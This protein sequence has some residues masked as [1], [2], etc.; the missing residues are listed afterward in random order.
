MRR[1]VLAS[2]LTILSPASLMAE[3]LIDKVVA[4]V[5]GVP[6]LHSEVETKVRSGFFSVSFFPAAEDAPIFEK[7]LQDAINF[8]LILQRAEELDIEVTDTELDQEINYNL[9]RRGQNKDGLVDA[10]KQAG[11]DY[12]EY[13]ED[14]RKQ[15][16]FR[17]FQG[18]V[19][20]PMIKITDKD[21]ETFYLKKT[22]S[23]A[24]NV[25]LIL[26]QI[27]I[28]VPEGSVDEVVQGKLKLARSIYQK[29][30]SGT[31]FEQA[32]RIYSD[33]EGARENGGLMSG[34]KLSDL[35]DSIRKEVE[36]LDAGK[37]T[38]PVRS[39]LGFHIFFLESKKFSGSDEFLKQKRELENELMMVEAEAQTKRWLTDFRR[40]NE[41]KIVGEA[42]K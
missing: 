7:A 37:F 18:M 27:L 12:Q 1:F 16:V 15:V 6:I 33:L 17:R 4:V 3:E 22:G 20:R 23:T 21:L 10:L 25:R 13:R 24:E 8:Q 11:M 28:K 41:I 31:E 39:P 2:V 19:I 35:S 42:A 9:E 5:N 34:V 40:K 36:K 30:E 32:A 14:F 26:R 29:L 38:L